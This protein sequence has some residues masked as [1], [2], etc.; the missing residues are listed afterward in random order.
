MDYN[1]FTKLVERGMEYNFV[2]RNEE[3]WISSIYNEVYCLTRCSDSYSQEFK[4]SG[5]LFAKA[6]IEGKSIFELWPYLK[7]ELPTL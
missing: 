6:Q 4:T 7:E 3:Y 1:E 2:Y 5:E